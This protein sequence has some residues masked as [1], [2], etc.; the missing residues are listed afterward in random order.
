[1]ARSNKP[2]TPK[3]TAP[4]TETTPET[5][6]PVTETTPDTNQS[7]KASGS[8][9]KVPRA[10]EKVIVKLPKTRELKDD[11]WVCVNDKKFQIKRGIE[12]E[13]PR[14]VAEVLANQERMLEERLAREEAAS[15]N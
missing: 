13:V 9:K 7:N 10:M 3:T 8:V 14:Y 6:A 5:T 2:K 4:V 15:L 12:V 1:M 11:A